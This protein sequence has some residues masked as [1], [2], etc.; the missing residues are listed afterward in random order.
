[1]FDPAVPLKMVAMLTRV[2]DVELSIVDKP[3]QSREKGAEQRDKVLRERKI[4]WGQ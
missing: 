2:A 4:T 1:M 3:H